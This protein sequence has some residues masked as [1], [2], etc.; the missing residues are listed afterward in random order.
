MSES[1][2]PLLSNT[3]LVKLIPIKVHNQLHSQLPGNDVASYL[4]DGDAGVSVLILSGRLSVAFTPNIMVAG[5]LGLVGKRHNAFAIK[6]TQ[7]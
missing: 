3:I 2:D 6:R 5:A 1:S 7:H 4:V